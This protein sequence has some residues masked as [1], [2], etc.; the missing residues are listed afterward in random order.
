MSIHDDDD[1][2]LERKILK[3]AV[4]A[5]DR[6]DNALELQELV[7]TTGASPER[8]EAALE[9]LCAKGYMRFEVWARH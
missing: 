4:A 5:Y 6:G 7:A 9:Q 8:V 1:Q 3:L 2:A